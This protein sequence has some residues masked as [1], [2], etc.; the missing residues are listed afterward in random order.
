MKTVFATLAGFY[1]VSLF[2]FLLFFKKGFL[3]ISG[4][5]SLPSIDV[6][7]SDDIVESE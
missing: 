6:N 7:C 1:S 4:E 5:S 3:Q 2:G